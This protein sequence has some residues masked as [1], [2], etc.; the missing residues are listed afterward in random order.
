MRFHIKE[1]LDLAKGEVLPVAHGDEF[2]KGA[3]QLECIAQNLPL[4]QALADA[5][6][7]LGEKVERINVLQNVGLAVGDEDHVQLVQGL[8]DEAYIVLLDRRVLGSTVGE[9]GERC[10]ESLNTGSLHLTELARED[11]L[12]AACA[13]GCC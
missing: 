12:A 3:K 4:V 6:N 5:G 1:G 2:I 13:D 10:Q 11:G 9:L 8:V 7:N